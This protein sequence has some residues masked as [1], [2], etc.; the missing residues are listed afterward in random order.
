MGIHLLTSF[1]KNLKK[2]GSYKV[3]LNTLSGKRIVV[4]ASIYLYRFKAMD[5]LI[6]NIYL[7]CTL[8]RVNNISALFVFD[9]K[10]T[11]NKE[12]T[13][14]K[15]KEQRDEAKRE[16][17]EIANKIE[18][19]SPEEREKEEEKMTE[20][21]RKFVKV[22]NNDIT[23][24]K[25]L[26]DAYGIKYMNATNEADELCAALVIKGAAYACLSEDSDLFAYGC[27]RVLKYISLL[28]HTVVV[29]PLGKILQSVGMRFSEFQQLCILSGT[30]YNESRRNIFA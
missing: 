20:L 19:M 23:D 13:L 12:S 14:L 22:T 4:D 28:N 1:L 11:K 21:R 8:F 26:L 10:S 27:P 15:R 18:R 6:E 30:D 29:Y 25:N 24:V 5:A 3:H 17:F 16:Y 9:G 2:N 7:L